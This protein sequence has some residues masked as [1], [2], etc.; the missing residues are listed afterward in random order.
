MEQILPLPACEAS[1]S[2]EF[3]AREMGQEQKNGVG[4]ISRP[5]KNLKIV[6]CVQKIPREHLLRRL[7]FNCQTYEFFRCKGLLLSRLASYSN[8]ENW[9]LWSVYSVN[10]QV[11]EASRVNKLT[12]SPVFRSIPTFV[13]LAKPKMAVSG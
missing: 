8:P 9:L 10:Q 11:F 7:P 12:K 6:F 4:G 2:V 13:V 5:S 1:V 3:Y